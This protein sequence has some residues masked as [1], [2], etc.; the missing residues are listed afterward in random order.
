M[1][2]L[3]PF[4]RFGLAGALVGAATAQV[5]F[6]DV[7]VSSGLLP[8]AQAGVSTAGMR[9]GATTGDFDRDGFQDIYVL[10]GFIRN[11]QLFLNNGDGTFREN[12]VKAGIDIR[13]RGGGA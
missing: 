8:T 3:A 1:S 13:H 5:K 7:T 9:P 6:T 12:S 11:D 4:A 2:S 10:G